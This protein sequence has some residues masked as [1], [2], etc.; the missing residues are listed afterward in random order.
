MHRS[1]TGPAQR[2]RIYVG[3]SHHYHHQPLYH[4]IVIKAREMGMAG[5]TVTQAI[6]GFGASSRI[7]SS[8]LLALSADL[9]IIIDIIDSREYIEKLLPEITHMVD[10]GLITLEDITVIQYHYKS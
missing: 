10:A 6:E 4:A 9:P 8:S 3:E 5:V 2:L 7:H 1:I